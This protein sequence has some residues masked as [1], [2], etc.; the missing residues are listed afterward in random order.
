MKVAVIFFLV[1]VGSLVFHILTPWWWTPVASNWGNIDDTIILTFWVTGFVFIAIGLFMVYCLWKFKYD[2]N[3]RSDYEPENKKL[4]INLTLITALGVAAMLAPGLFV[5]N[6]YVNVPD[7]AIEMEVVAYQWGWKY[8]LPGK[9]GKL[10]KVDVKLMK[11]NNIFGID[12]KDPNGKDD[13]L[14]DSNDVQI[15]INQPV[16]VLLRSIDVLHNFYVPQF[17]AK[18]DAVPGLITFYWF[19]PTRTGTFEILCAEFCGTGHYAMRG[20]VTVSNENDYSS[21]IAKQV[22]FEKSLA[23][24]I[25][26]AGVASAKTPTVN[27]KVEEKLAPITPLLASASIEA[28]AEI[29]KRCAAC[30]SIEKGGANK[31]G[32]ALWGTVNR[33][34]G[35]LEGFKYSAALSNYGKNWTF[36]ELNAFLHKPMKYIKG[37]KMA[38]GGLKNETDRANIIAFM[39]SK[40][41][42]PAP[43]K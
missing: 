1:V 36:E 39:N 23:N 15:K 33:K 7:N 40:G 9:D 12:P 4:E 30:H 32:P 8:R 16:K 37:T 43:L 31:I 10:G 3:K 11:D 20:K 42:N 18:M 29:F 28:G 25:E 22:T 5:W 35:A 17:R 14:V 24:K 19:E 34:V 27:K 13:V 21:W 6:K 2:K 26:G 41:D 38:F